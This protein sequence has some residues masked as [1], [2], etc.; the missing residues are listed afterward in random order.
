MSPKLVMVS[1][2]RSVMDIV[3]KEKENPDEESGVEN[4]NA[5]EDFEDR[6]VMDDEFRRLTMAFHLEIA[7]PTVPHSI[8]AK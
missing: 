8:Q 3:D 7:L 2:S 5:D 4:Y 1:S 6:D